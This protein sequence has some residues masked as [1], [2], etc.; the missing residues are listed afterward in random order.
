MRG[1]VWFRE[2][3]RT[4]DNTALYHANKLCDEGVFGVYVIDHEMWKAHDMAVCR[5]QFIREALK[6]L[7][8]EL[9]FYSIPFIILE[10]TGTK[11]LIQTFHEWI[12]KEKIGALFFNRQYEIDEMRR[13]EKIAQ[14]FKKQGKEVFSYHDQTILPPG[15]V[16]TK[17]DTYFKVFTAYKRAWYNKFLESGGLKL[18]SLNPKCKLLNDERVS[19]QEAMRRLNYFIKNHLFSYHEARDFPALD[20]TSH[21]SPY[22]AA[23]LI[24]ARECF[25]AALKANQFELDTGNEG[26]VTWM[27]ELIWRDFYKHILVAVPRVSMHLPYQ[28]QTEK[29]K[30]KTNGAHLKAWQEGKT[31]IPIVDAAMRQLNQTGWMHNRLRMVTAMFFTKNLFLDWRVGEKYFMTHLIDGDLSANN[32]GWQWC[33]STGTD[34]APYF[35]VFNPISQSERFDPQGEFIRQYCPELKELDHYAIHAPYERAPLLMRH[36]DYPKPIVDL[37][38]TRQYAIDRFKNV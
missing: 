30:W 32:G 34:A 20:A 28:L 7:E 8:K 1:L 10:L 13:D 24:S 5:E 27:N 17:E 29:I 15:S 25:L 38:L 12:S 33:A 14:F 36:I 11:N 22:L 16:I 19:S 26:A 31:G 2:D 35:R 18:N 21:L 3:L 23:G 37:K 6:A 9:S 4:R